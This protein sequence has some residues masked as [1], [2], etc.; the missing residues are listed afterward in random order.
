MLLKV[1]NTYLKKKILI[2]VPLSFQH[3][4]KYKNF[5]PRQFLSNIST[6]MYEV[7]T[8]I[9]FHNK[10]VPGE[11]GEIQILLNVWELYYAF[12]LILFY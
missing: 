10:K 2:V 5:L 8:L 9:I 11:K 4:V 7:K 3:Y 6:C 12:W 1:K